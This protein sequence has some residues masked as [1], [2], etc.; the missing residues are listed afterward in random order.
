MLGLT[1][2]VRVG[3]RVGFEVGNAVVVT[4]SSIEDP[5]TV[6]SATFSKVVSVSQEVQS[7]PHNP[8]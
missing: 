4:I 8:S 1:V 2:G 5:Q 7:V 3:A 6:G